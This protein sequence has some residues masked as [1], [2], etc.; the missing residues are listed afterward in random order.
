MLYKLHWQGSPQNADDKTGRELALSDTAPGLPMSEHRRAN[1]CTVFTQGTTLG[2]Q[3]LHPVPT[4]WNSV[5][6]H[7]RS[8]CTLYST[9]VQG[10]ICPASASAVFKRY[11]GLHSL[12]VH[13][14]LPRVAPYHCPDR[15]DWRVQ[16]GVGGSD[17]LLCG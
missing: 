14:R 8:S 1:P 6:E 5:A 7:A 3:C 16:R 11:P 15:A 13:E 10:V 2:D 12:T 17:S 9:F 4:T